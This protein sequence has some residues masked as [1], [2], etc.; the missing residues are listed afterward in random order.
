M[1]PDKQRAL[2]ALGRMET[3]L[4]INHV[5]DTFEVSPQ[6]RWINQI[7]AALTEP[8]RKA[9]LKRIERLAEVMN[10]AVNV[11]YYKTKSPETEKQYIGAL[12]AYRDLQLELDN[13]TSE[14]QPPSEPTDEKA[15]KIPTE[16]DEAKLMVLLGMHYLKQHAPTAMR[17]PAPLLAFLEDLVRDPYLDPIPNSTYGDTE[18]SNEAVTYGW[19][20]C[21]EYFRRIAKQA[22]REYRGEE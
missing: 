17:D 2:E 1:T 16:V 7:H 12:D 14:L 19:N 22:L 4:R 21:A 15:V 11:A 3:M 13:L 20:E 5:F 8:D 6:Y 18:Y 9:A 10:Q